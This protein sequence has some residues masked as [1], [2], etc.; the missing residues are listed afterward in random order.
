ML[1]GPGRGARDYKVLCVGDSNVGKTQFMN[2]SCNIA[3]FNEESKAT[4]G[5]SFSTRKI[6]VKG[7]LVPIAIWDTAGQERYRSLTSAYFRGTHGVFLC[8]AINN[9]SSFDNLQSWNSEV[10]NFCKPDVV[11]M[12]V[13]T[14]SDLGEEYREVSTEDAQSYAASISASYVETSSKTKDNV[15]FALGTKKF[16]LFLFNKVY[17]ESMHTNAGVGCHGSCT[18]KRS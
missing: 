8:F 14:K 2:V 13:G 11:R 15:E 5:V 12:V 10:D 6:M 16:R 18:R 17:R 7:K 1:A 4:I 9:K 3:A